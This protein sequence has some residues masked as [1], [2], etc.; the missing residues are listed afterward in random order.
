MS[1]SKPES[2]GAG[3][4]PVLEDLPVDLVETTTPTTEGTQVIPDSADDVLVLLPDGTDGDV[5]VVETE[6]VDEDL[7]S[8]QTEMVDTSVSLEDVPLKRANPL[9][10]D[11]PPELAEA[12]QPGGFED[13]AAESEEDLFG[14]EP[15]AEEKPARPERRIDRPRPV[16]EFFPAAGAES[17]SSRRSWKVPIGLAAAALIAAGGYLSYPHW[18]HFI[19]G[20][21]VAIATPRGGGTTAIVDTTKTAPGGA[22]KAGTKAVSSD[23]VRASRDAFREKF[24]LTVELGYVGEVS[25]E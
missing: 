20:E 8:T 5:P 10:D 13:L 6:S 16:P 12:E 18:R 11:A 15:Q 2:E 9:T 21:R 1:N 7:A 19:E 3:Q 24:L 4:E 22:G 25:N 17:S 23:L 14:P